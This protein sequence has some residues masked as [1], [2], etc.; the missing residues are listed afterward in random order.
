[1][2]STYTT[3]DE[4]ET[5]V[6]WL[7]IS[8]FEVLFILNYNQVAS[9]KLTPARQAGPLEIHHVISE[10]ENSLSYNKI[11]PCKQC[12]SETQALIPKAGKTKEGTMQLPYQIYRP[13]S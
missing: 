3:I 4:H 13:H 1:M 12:K 10:L 5:G 2:N 8:F 11:Q 9:P 7:I 6:Y